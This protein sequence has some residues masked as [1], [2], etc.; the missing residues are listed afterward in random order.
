[1]FIGMTDRG[2]AAGGGEAPYGL[3]RIEWTGEV[4]FEVKAV[5]VM[6][7]GFE[8]EFTKPADPE[9]LDNPSLYNIQSFIYEYRSAY[10]SP[11]IDV[12]DNPILGVKASEDGARVR[13]VVDNLRR[14]HI[15]EIKLGELASRD[16]VPLLHSVAY[17]T[18]NNI[19]DGERLA[20]ERAARSEAP[21]ATAEGGAEAP[22]ETVAGNVT[23][24][25]EAWS[26]GPDV[27]VTLAA[28]P[29]LRFD[30]ESFEV[31]SGARIRLSLENEDDII[32]NVVIVEPGS[33]DEVGEAAMSIGPGG[34][35]QGY[36]PDSE[37]V[38]YYTRLLDEG[39]AESIYFTAPKEPGTYPFICTVPG[40]HIT[41][42]GTMVVR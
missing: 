2:W 28:V 12:E 6:P 15:Y 42:R 13:L 14:Y 1:M 7:D 17:Y 29:G 24:M 27:S 36:I 35:Q 19:P 20:L 23:E 4:P 9:D 32:H 18:L 39:E 40:H 33:A 22:S 38:L 34:M 41:M 31:P 30:R 25:P 11:I 21:S 16:G 26:D 3:Q 37:S 8:L 5:R 10:A